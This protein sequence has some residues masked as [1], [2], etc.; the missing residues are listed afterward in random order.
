MRARI[1]RRSSQGANRLFLPLRG[2]RRRPR[3]D[4]LVGVRGVEL[5]SVDL[6]EFRDPPHRLGTERCLALEGV[7]DD[8]LE[9]VAER[10]I[11]VF[12]Q[13]LEHLEQTLFHAYAGLYSLDLCHGIYVPK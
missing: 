8:A 12:G 10:E 3:L 2:Y 1:R 5:E 4:Q 11:V 13:R 9:Q 7:K 6:P